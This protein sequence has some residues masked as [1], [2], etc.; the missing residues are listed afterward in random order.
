[1]PTFA[2]KLGP[3]SVLPK[4]LVFILDK[5]FADF[6]D[7]LADVVEDIEEVQRNFETEVSKTIQDLPSDSKVKSELENV[8]KHNKLVESKFSELIRETNKVFNVLEEKIEQEIEQYE[9]LSKE[10]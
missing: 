10:Q 2:T 6:A 5:I 7:N 1:M 4:I 9:A 8:V 3:L